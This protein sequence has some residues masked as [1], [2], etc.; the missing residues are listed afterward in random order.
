MIY[1]DNTANN[2][3]DPRI[4]KA[5]VPYIEEYYGNPSSIHSFG[6]KCKDAIEEARD[7]IAELINVKS[8]EIIYTSCGT[9]SNN[10][11]LKGVCLANK[12][13]GNH[14]IISG[15]EHFSIMHAATTLERWGFEVTRVGVDE[16]GM[17]DP[18][19][20]AEAINDETILV[21]IIHANHE[22]GTIQP[23]E[24]ISKITRE[25]KILFHT[26]AIASVGTI[27]VDVQELGVDLL[28]LAG[29]QF[30][31]PKGAAAL[32]I[33]T[34]VKIEPLLDGGIQ[35][36]GLRAG[37]ENVAGIFGMGIA[38]RLS[39]EEMKNRNQH[40]I[41]LRDRLIEEIPKR[42]SDVHILGHLTKRLPGNVSIAV[43]FIEGESMLLF[44]D[45]EGIEISSGSACISRSLKVSHIMTAMNVETATAQGSLL[46]SIGK[47]NTME[48]IDK[49]LEALPPIVQRLRDMSPLYRRA[50]KTD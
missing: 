43:E 27:P 42:I 31:G 8:K 45:M 47:D 11:A 2:K 3:L 21:S 40:I 6:E 36:R 9:E 37:T 5:M 13:K 14:L 25:K 10:F 38:A 24:E 30:Y 4:Y 33:R 41:K 16:Y 18:Q 32:Y 50:H 49:V 1:L 19:E 17:V 23:I 46:F 39:I 44:L 35:E 15:V 29:N 28:S 12:K 34:G 26:D 22:V 20:I 7:N 48:D